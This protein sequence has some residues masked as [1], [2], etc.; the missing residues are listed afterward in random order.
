[1][2]SEQTL[3][4]AR[5]LEAPGDFSTVQCARCQGDLEFH[6]PDMDAPHRILAT[7]GECGS[8]Y[9]LDLAKAW[10]LAFPRFEGL[11]EA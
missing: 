8:W 2:T 11:E 1:M 7:C 9:L 6:Q 4:A 5:R 3:P 10:I